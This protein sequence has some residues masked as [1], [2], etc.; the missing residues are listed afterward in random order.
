MAAIPPSPPLTR[1]GLNLA[2]YV[3]GRES[4]LVAAALLVAVLFPLLHRN[5]GDIDTAATACAFIIL[6][7]GL[8]IV[9]GYTGMLHLGFA[10]FFGIG[11]YAYGVLSS[12]Q[13]TPAWNDYWAPLEALGLVEHVR[14]P[15]GDYV[16]LCVP[17][18]LMLP[19]SGIIAAGFAM[20]FGA[21]TL[22][23]K[24]D[25]LAIVTLGFGEIVPIVAR[26]TPALTNGAMGLNGVTPPVFF[27]YRFGVESW[28][29]YYVGLALVCVLILVS[30]R[31]RASRIGRAWTALRDDEIGA[32]AMGVDPVKLKLL[33]L[34][35]GGGFAG[36]AGAFY[37]AKLQTASPDMFMLPVSI[38]VLVMIVLGGMGSVAGVVTGALL[39]YLLQSWLLQDLTEWIQAAGR[40]LGSELL[41]RIDLVRG[42]ELI[43]GVILVLMMLWRRQGLFPA[44]AQTAALTLG[45]QTALPS[46]GEIKR[47]LS[48]LPGANTLPVSVPILETRALVKRFG[49]VTAVKA[50]NLAMFPGQIVAII[51]PNGSGKST[52]F[53]LITGVDRPDDGRILFMGQ[54]ITGLP[55]HR[56]AERGIARTF[57]NLRVFSDLNVMENVLVGAHCRTRTG[58]LGAVLRTPRVRRE[59]ADSRAWVLELAGVFGNRLLPRLGHFVQG[60]SYA[61]RRRTEIMRALA[62]EPKLLLLDEPTAGMNPAETLEL[63]AQLQ[64]LKAM[65][66]SILLIEHKLHILNDIA[67]KVIVL[68]H[69]EKIAEGSAEEVQK[70]V[71]VI[72]AYLGRG[73][74]TTLQ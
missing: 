15:A 37:V 46:R 30:Y 51:G 33:A 2:H 8:N 27:G 34:A 3:R 59:E 60:L 38:M 4:W 70:N 53:N 39:L 14:S 24:G 65:G 48:R 47:P 61:N 13:V 26:N 73:A 45:E 43:F 20:L 23:L 40:G 29:F 6:A 54:D 72:S 62:T 18:W 5:D 7:L 57:Q 55:P 9:V 11:A 31:L 63:A 19:I 32:S 68:D 17:F 16:H 21:P 28:P 35:I 58:A 66:F 74:A 36:V 52:L 22:R 71:E 25:Y 69:G 41:L 10:A 12:Y 67:D 1:P 56:I 44:M 49:G 42:T 50:L 64:H